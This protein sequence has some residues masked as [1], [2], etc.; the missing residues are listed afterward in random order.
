MIFKS[1]MEV[2]MK[3]DNIILQKTYQFALRIIKVCLFLREKGH[4]EIASQIFRSGTSIGANTEEAVGGQ[5]EKD[6]Q[7]KLSIAYKEARESHFWIRLL[8]DSNIITLKMAESFLNDCE[9]IQKILGSIIKTL[10]ANNN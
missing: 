8:R 4:Y 10:K 5:S 6:L 7:S 3:K 1:L 9:E 2:K